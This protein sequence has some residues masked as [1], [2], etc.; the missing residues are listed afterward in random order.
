MTVALGCKLGRASN[1]NSLADIINKHPDDRP[2]DRRNGPSQTVGVSSTRNLF[3]FRK[4]LQIIPIRL[5][6]VLIQ[7]Y[8]GKSSIRLKLVN[9]WF[10]QESAMDFQRS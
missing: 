3:P 6:M 7:S 2:D 4:S 10:S 8:P 5:K 9:R 1:C